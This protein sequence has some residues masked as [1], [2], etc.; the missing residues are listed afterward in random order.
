VI[1]DTGSTDD[2]IE[3]IN[4]LGLKYGISGEVHRHAWVS[5]AH[6]RNKALEAAVQSRINNQHQCTRVMIIDAD[7]ELE[8]FD[9]QWKQKLEWGKSYNTYRQTDNWAM[10]NH[11]L[12]WIVDKEWI[13]KGDIHNFITQL[14]GDISNGFLNSVA[15]RY[16]VFEGAKSHEFSN[17]I[18]KALKDISML[19][20]EL[21]QE[22]ISLANNFRFIQLAFAYRNAG[23][24]QVAISVMEKLIDCPG[25][26]ADRLY[27]ALLFCAAL[28]LQN[29]VE[30]VKSRAYLERAAEILPTRKEAYFYLSAWFRE[31]GQMDLATSFMKQA[32]DARFIDYGACFLERNIYT[33]KAAYQ[34]AFLLYSNGEIQHAEKLVGELMDVA[35][36]PSSEKAF[37]DQLNQ[38]IRTKKAAKR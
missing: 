34:L 15:I 10:K 12:F 22:K 9:P 4:R 38:R 7:E 24:H 35:Q 30:P 6:N 14:N 37:I 27:T 28:L 33:W 31:N 23:N 16:H 11:F 5:F 25:I 20:A 2:T 36:I 8:V 26:S 21:E 3:V 32:Y 18:E 13:W 19:H 1:S 17:T 29:K